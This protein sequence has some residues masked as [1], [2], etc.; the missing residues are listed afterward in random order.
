MQYT[1]ILSKLSLA[2]A[3]FLTPHKCL[4]VDRQLGFSIISLR[5]PT[6]LLD[7]FKS[8]TIANLVSRL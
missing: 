5:S 7:R 8:F 4:V 1:R 2:L 6:R 3:I